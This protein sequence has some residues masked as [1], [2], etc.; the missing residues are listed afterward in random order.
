MYRT[1]R[2]PALAAVAFILCAGSAHAAELAVNGGFE[3]GDLTVDG[4][5]DLRHR[6]LQGATSGPQ[7]ERRQ[8]L[9][10]PAILQ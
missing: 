5:L 7:P 8:F 9:V 2:K 10:R 1:F 3:T 4:Q 6:S